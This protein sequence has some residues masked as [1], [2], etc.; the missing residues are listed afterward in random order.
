MKATEDLMTEHRVI[1]RMLTAL[2]TAAARLAEGQP[3]R[4][5]FFLDTTEF[6]QGFAD[7]CH[8][9]KEENVLF[10]ALI[11]HGMPSRGGPVAVMLSEHE[12]GRAFI[13]ALQEAAQRLAAG[14]ETA[15]DDVIANSNGY[16]MLLRQ[17][18]AKED[19]VLFVMANQIIPPAAQAQVNEDCERLEQETEGT[20]ER[21]LALADQLAQE[22]AAP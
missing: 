10:P 16:A 22:A 5:G 19:N 13:R 15:R 2:E 14:D 4:A 17:H 8:H 12:Q 21:Y 3:L 1:E 6:L 7:G 18:I 11:A 9:R 20:H